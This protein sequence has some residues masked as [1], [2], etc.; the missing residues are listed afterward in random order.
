MWGMEGITR[1]AEYRTCQ[2]SYEE[3]IS[4]RGDDHDPMEE[5]RDLMEKAEELG[6]KCKESIAGPT[7]RAG[8]VKN[9]S[10]ARE[11]HSGSR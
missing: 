1:G 2:I 6:V 8:S 3:D 4:R 10:F 5:M 9:R 7:R 11:F